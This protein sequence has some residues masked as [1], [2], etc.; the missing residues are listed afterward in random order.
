MAKDKNMPYN[1]WESVMDQQTTSTV[2]MAFK[3]LEKGKASEAQQKLVLDFLIK[4]GCRTY[5]TD[6]FL[7]ERISSFAA[8]RRYV[9][10]QIVRFIN[11]K[12]GKIN[13]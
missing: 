10:L 6:W 2:S 3:A 5:D 8:G 1:N 13:K 9:G 12:V 4:I 7:D 11:L